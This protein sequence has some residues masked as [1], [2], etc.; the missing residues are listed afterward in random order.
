MYYVDNIQDFRLQNTNRSIYLLEKFVLTCSL[1]SAQ[2][3]NRA[4]LQYCLINEEEEEE[5]TR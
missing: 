3:L 4:V 5:D 2:R 1:A